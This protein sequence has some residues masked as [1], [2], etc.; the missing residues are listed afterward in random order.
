MVALQMGYRPKGF[1][2]DKCEN[3]IFCFK[4]HLNSFSVHGYLNYLMKHFWHVGIKNDPTQ[5]YFFFLVPRLINIWQS[6]RKWNVFQ[7]VKR[8]FSFYSRWNAVVLTAIL[9]GTTSMHGQINSG[10]LILV[11]RIISL[12]VVS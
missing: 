11:V 6:W 8:F 9:I 1:V 4:T 12:G 5:R 10:F 2:L 3:R 7:I